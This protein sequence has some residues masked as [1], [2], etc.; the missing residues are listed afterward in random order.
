[1]SR[2]LNFF[3]TKSGIK[4]G[5]IMTRNFVAV[6]PDANLVDCAREM[7]KK[8]VGSLVLKD[9]QKLMG[10]LTE[11]DIIWAMTKK[12]AKGLDKIKARDVASKK[13]ATIKPGADLY[14]AL[15]RMKKLKFRRLPV[16]I[17]GNVIGMLTLKDVLRIEP[18]LFSDINKIEEV[19]EE[20]EKLKRM[21]GEKWV[22]DGICEEC[23]NSDVLYKVDNR[24]ICLQCKDAM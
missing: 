7:M 12:G 18:S 20:S 5:D 14:E 10:L 17:N 13:I 22:T 16:V 15:Q 11:K 19:R 8:R 24:T 21:K 4:V 3:R 2:I 6:K 9:G 1:M 23:G